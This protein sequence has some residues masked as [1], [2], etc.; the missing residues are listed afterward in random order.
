LRRTGW[1]K[2]APR[3]TTPDAPPPDMD[4]VLSVTQVPPSE[5]RGVGVCEGFRSNPPPLQPVW[6]PPHWGSP[7][8]GARPRPGA[9]PARSRAPDTPCNHGLPPRQG[10][11][12]PGR[13]TAGQ[14]KPWAFSPNVVCLELRLDRAQYIFFGR[15]NVYFL[16]LIVWTPFFLLFPPSPVKRIPSLFCAP[17]NAGQGLPPPTRTQT[18]F[19]FVHSVQLG[20]NH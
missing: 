6:V 8:V 19:R 20:P 17:P 12:R 18:F 11:P 13:R 14:G 15:L 5:G 1:R 3:A 10:R 2:I 16:G 9:V 7:A 4:H